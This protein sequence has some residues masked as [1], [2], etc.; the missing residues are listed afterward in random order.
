MT[1]NLPL[2][3]GERVAVVALVA[4][5]IFFWVWVGHALTE[6]GWWAP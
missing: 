4:V 3:V 6:A 2:T 5:A 1:G